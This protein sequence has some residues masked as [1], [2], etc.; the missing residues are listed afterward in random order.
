[1]MKGRNSDLAGNKGVLIEPVGN[2]YKL[3]LH[4]VDD[5]GD[6]IAKGKP[7]VILDTAPDEAIGKAVRDLFRTRVRAP[8]K[9]KA[10]A[11]AGGAA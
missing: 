8:R 5:I 2:A 9:A 11:A 1:M 6:A 4:V 10:P 7:V 3:Q